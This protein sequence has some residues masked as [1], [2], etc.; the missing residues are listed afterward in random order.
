MDSGGK[1]VMAIGR[2]C[3][4]VALIV[5]LV[6]GCDRGPGERSGPGP[7]NTAG[8][9]KPPASEL[10]ELAGKQIGSVDAGVQ[11]V[12]VLPLA[13]GCQDYLG[14]YVVSLARA[15]PDFIGVRVLDMGGDAGRTAMAA[16]GAKCMSVIVNGRTAFDLGGKDGKVLLE[17]PGFGLEDLRRVVM[18]ELGKTAGDAA[19]QLPPAPPEPEIGVRRP[20]AAAHPAPAAD[21]PANGKGAQ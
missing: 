16:C 10:L 2:G 13:V 19:P 1:C 8:T 11:I 5:L 9:G 4:L 14:E 18:A 6:A 20:S 3:L 15:N 12:C 17:G 21:P 7:G